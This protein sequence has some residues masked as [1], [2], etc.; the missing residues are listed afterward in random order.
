MGMLLAG[1]V[2]L[3]IG[4]YVIL[5]P[6]RTFNYFGSPFGVSAGKIRFHYPNQLQVEGLQ[7]EKFGRVGQANLLWQW[8]EISQRKIEFLEISD[9]SVDLKKDESIVDESGGVRSPRTRNECELT[10][11]LSLQNFHPPFNVKNLIIHRAEIIF[12]EQQKLQIEKIHLTDTD[13]VAL[14]IEQLR[15]GET[16]A[17]GR[18][19]SQWRWGELAQRKITSVR[20]SDAKIDATHLGKISFSGAS[21]VASAPQ[22]KAP[23]SFL[24]PAI[25]QSLILENVEIILSPG[26]KAFFEKA[27]MQGSLEDVSRLMIRNLS[28][29]DFAKIETIKLDWTWEGLAQREVQYVDIT[30]AHISL[31]RLMAALPA[32]DVHA[33][34]EESN[35]LQ[36]GFRLKELRIRQSQ[37]TKNIFGPRMPA[38][39]LSIAQAA[40]D[41]VF[42]DLYLGGPA[43][44]PAAKEPVEAVIEN[45]TITSPYDG[46]SPMI[47]F[48]QIRVVFSWAGIQAQRIDQLH[49][50]D[51]VIHIGN[52]LFWFTNDIKKA[53]AELAPQEEAT[54]SNP[55]SIGIFSLS[56][57]KIA[58]TAYGRESVK[59][60]FH[61]SIE[62]HFD[63]VVGD[64]TQ[65]H[66]K[67]QCEI[68]PTTIEYPEYGML[69]FVNLRGK[70]EFSLP[71]DDK[72]ANNIVNSLKIDSI[73]W[74]GVKAQEGQLWLTYDAKGIYG[75]FYASAY[76][77]SIGGDV[78]FYWDN[79]LSW[80]GSCYT[81]GVDIEPATKLLYPENFLMSGPVDSR[82]VVKGEAREILGMGGTVS[83]NQNGKMIIPAVDDLL[84][85][86]PPEWPPFKKEIASTALKAFRNYDY[87]G[88]V[89]DFAYSPP[90]SFLKLDLNGL[91]GKRNFNIT[92]NDETFN[93][94]TL[95]P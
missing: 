49:I 59:L 68:P 10:R 80:I 90:K 64:F 38:F 53:Q 85:K 22:A 54:P 27:E 66:L 43:D 83:L 25:I 14:R 20:I 21:A 76:S 73:E 93:H 28:V 16:V 19:Q 82:F 9:L 52:D 79:A 65:L 3:G 17:V 94:I 69:R 32:K 61:F 60:P 62:P 57:G 24:P 26:R 48:G 5:F 2:L 11:P 42:R 88:G 12:S 86:I 41:L 87:Y 18:I 50:V 91:Q 55:W 89:C 29:G 33:P 78:T 92:W 34:A 44:D 58:L 39:A 71:L 51:P 63:L 36:T 81:K 67:T 40:P 13:S 72:Q 77:G 70:M 35:G 84:Q 37:I 6:T 46:I 31:D 30:N 47:T 45:Y 95:E 74:K 23:S 7:V 15:V 75:G 1:V 4:A 56:G 8:S